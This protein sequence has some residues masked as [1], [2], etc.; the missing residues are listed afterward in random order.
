MLKIS[1]VSHP[2]GKARLGEV[3]RFSLEGQTPGLEI[4]AFLKH[5][6]LFF[7]KPLLDWASAAPLEV[8]P[9][10]PGRYALLVEWRAP[11]GS[12]GSVEQ[13]FRVVNVV[14]AVE[15]TAVDNA[16]RIVKLDRT[17]R[18]WVPSEWE[19]RMLDGYEDATLKHLDGIVK[20]G[21]VAYD[22]GASLGVYSLRL[23]RLVGSGGRVYSIEANPVCV[24]FLQ[25]TLQLNK[26]LNCEIL[27][28]AILDSEKLAYFTINYS[29][30][31]LGL[32][33]GAS[34]GGGK[35]GHEI[36]VRSCGLDDLVESHHLRRPD[37]V[38]I[39]IEGAE[40]PAVAGMARTIARDRPV[41][42][43]EVHGR[44]AAVETFRAV[45]WSGY[46]FEHP[47]GGEKFAD[48]ASLLAWFTDAVRQI[49]CLPT[50]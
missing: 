34:G 42:L 3:C 6:Q 13:P 17:T 48:A 49:I 29:N 44:T 20:P 5:E 18:V 19:A 21:W 1:I 12:R 35:T 10:A 16:P 23:S 41:I 36:A 39:D 8:F 46:R 31:G 40:G 7:Q 50:P 4:R 24:Y 2:G 14:K 25:A 37:F 33:Q 26:V 32:T 47:A 43:I 38:K 27:P 28:V 30:F 11:D 22:I 9:E 15:T 45:D